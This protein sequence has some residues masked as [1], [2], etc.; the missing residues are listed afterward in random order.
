MCPGRDKVGDRLARVVLL[1]EAFADE[2]RVR[3]CRCICEQVVRTAHAAFSDFH[4]GFR[5]QRGDACKRLAI[6]FERA[7]VTC[8]DADDSRTGVDCGSREAGRL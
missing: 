5:Q 4:D 3:A 6:D 2:H 7:K 1:D 8:I